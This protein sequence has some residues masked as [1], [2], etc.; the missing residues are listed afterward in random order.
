MAST[1]A[2]V[3]REVEPVI[4]NNAQAVDGAG[5]PLWKVTLDVRTA[6][7]TKYLGHVVQCAA[8]N[9]AG[10]RQAVKAY[11]KALDDAEQVVMV[12]TPAAILALIGQPVDL[13]FNPV[14]DWDTV[15]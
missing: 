15:P 4:V 5:L 10:I 3:W 11:A 8:S 14:L 9:G 7:G 1:I 6:S 2:F 12:K 13:Q